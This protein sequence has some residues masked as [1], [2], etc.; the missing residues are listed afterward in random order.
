MN[1]KKM[2]EET[3]YSIISEYGLKVNSINENEVE[4]INPNFKISINC[5]FGEIY[6]LIK[7]DNDINIKP[8]LWAYCLNKISF[9]DIPIPIYPKEMKIDSIVKYNLFTECNYIRIFCKEL[10]LGDFSKKYIYTENSQSVLKE[11]NTYYEKTI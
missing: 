3:F 6:V 4:L 1:L 7:K 8:L 5:N 9:K 10:L 11:I 2:V